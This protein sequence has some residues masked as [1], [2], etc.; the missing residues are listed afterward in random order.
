MSFG[1]CNLSVIPG[2]SEPSDKAEM[3][4]QVLFGEHFDIVEENEKWYRIKLDHDGY[5]CWVNKNQ[6]RLLSEEDEHDEEDEYLV[7]E[8]SFALEDLATNNDLNVVLGSLL[9]PLAGSQFNIGADEY[10]YEGGI[11]NFEEALADQIPNYAFLYLNTPYLW[12]GRTPFGID[13][14]GFTQMV[15]RMCGFA[16]PRDSHEQADEGELIELVEEAIE[17]DIAFF[18]NKNTKI[19]HVGIILSGD[20]PGKKQI[21][22]ASGKVRIDDFD[23]QGI[24]NRKK[25]E[26]S[27]YLVQI[28]RIVG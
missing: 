3:I 4:N 19:S 18:A 15:Y 9:P 11:V 23:E 2:R 7:D 13:C 16:L 10:K 12:G 25:Q 22:H 28:K 24:F 26:Y 27:H 8:L 1:Y 21:I 6:I 14:S 20:Q 17:G 5:E